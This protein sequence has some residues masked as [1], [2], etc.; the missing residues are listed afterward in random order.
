MNKLTPKQEKFCNLY[1]E[2]GNASEAYRQ[3]YNVIDALSSTITENASRLLASSN[4]SARV[5][6]LQE[7][8]KETHSITRD[9]IVKGLLEIISDADYTFN[10]GKDSKLTKDDSKAFYRIMQQTKNTDKL[11]ALETLAKMLGLNEPEK[12]DLNVKSFKTNWG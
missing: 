9:Y 12:I 5:A 3:A 6:E 2:L 1:I 10:L 4:V 11:R 7:S 8:V